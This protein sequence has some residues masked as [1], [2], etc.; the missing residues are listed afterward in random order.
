MQIS[1]DDDAWILYTS[2]TTGKPKGARLSHRNLNTALIQSAIAYEPKPETCFLNAMP[3]CHIAGYLTPLHQF[4][5]GTVLMMSGWDP[6]RWMQLVRDNRVTSGGFAPTMMQMLLAHPKINDYDLSSLEWMGYGASK[7]PVDV[8]RQHHRALRTRRVRRHGDDRARR[9]HADPRQG[10]HIRAANG[11]EYLLDA[12]G[13]PMSLVDV[14]VVGPAG[15]RLPRRQIGEIV[16]KGDQ[17]TKG[18]FGNPEANAQ[19]FGAAGSTPATWPGRTT[20]GSS[21][22]ST[23]PRT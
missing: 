18:Y 4:H 16:V 22:S 2:G 6:E 14:R 8:L 21:T 3:L 9:Q 10:A 15:K 5:G 7:I 19:A 23:E 12:V 1:E 11:E 17:V 13:K 20:R